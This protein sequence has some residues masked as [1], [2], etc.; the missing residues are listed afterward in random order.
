MLYVISNI[1]ECEDLEINFNRCNLT[2]NQIRMLANVLAEKQGRLQ[3]KGLNISGNKLAED[4]IVTLF[5]KASIAFQ[6]LKEL[7]M[8]LEMRVLIPFRRQ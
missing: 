7:V 4:S 3:V 6:A 2:E 8:R 1:R 5:R